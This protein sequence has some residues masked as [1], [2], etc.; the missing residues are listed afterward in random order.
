MADLRPQNYVIPGY[1]RAGYC[2]PWSPPAGL[3]NVNHASMS[4]DL[5]RLPSYPEYTIEFN[6]WNRESGG[7]ALIVGEPYAVRLYHTLSWP[8]I[9]AVDRDNWETFF[10]TVA[11]AQSEPWTW[12]NPVHGNALTVRF[13]DPDFPATPEIGYGYHQL[14]GLRIMVDINYTGQP[15]FG[16]PTYTASMGT[17]FVLGSM[18]LQ[19]PAPVRPDTG[20]SLTT[21]YARED[22]S[23]GRPVVCRIGKTTRH[24]WTLS[25]TNLRY[26]HWTRLQAFFCTFARGKK[27]PFVW[28]DTD[29]TA[30]TVRLAEPRLT[31][32][33]TGYNTLSCTMPLLEEL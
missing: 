19:L 16:T 22:S 28:Y 32:K 7:G 26:L 23:A 13:A 8:S 1:V 10:H 3:K 15:L 18:V 21:R 33:Q 30:R 29:G 5:A 20:Y 6:Q 27:N 17:A 4:F 25:W 12:W 2:A 31:V 14:S 24:Y 11:R 9:C